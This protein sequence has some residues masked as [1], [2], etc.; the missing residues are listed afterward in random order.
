MGRNVKFHLSQLKDVRLNVRTVSGKV[1]LSEA[2]TSAVVEET[3]IVEN[4]EIS[5]LPV[6]NV[7]KK[8]QYLSNRHKAS[9][10]FVETVTRI[11][12]IREIDFR[13]TE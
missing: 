8:Q 7:R 11:L 5:T 1:D 9:Q 3:S 12:R 6:P 2:E 10:C 13:F 4:E